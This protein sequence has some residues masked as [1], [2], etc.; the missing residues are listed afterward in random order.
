MLF[1]VKMC[2]SLTFVDLDTLDKSIKASIVR[3]SG[4]EIIFAVKFRF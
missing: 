2:S 1:S 4:M 3:F